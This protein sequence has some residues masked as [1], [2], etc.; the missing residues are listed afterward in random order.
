MYQSL[1]LELAE[2][3]SD[4]FSLTV[5]GTSMR[6]ALRPGDRIVVQKTPV[7]QLQVGD[8][9]VFRRE[10]VVITHRLLRGKDDQLLTK[11]D[12]MRLLDPPVRAEAVLGRADQLLGGRGPLGVAWLSWWEA[13][14]YGWGRLL[15]RYPARGFSLPFTL[16]IRFLLR[17]Y[18][19]V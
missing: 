6:P 17:L 5:N 8:L 14:M 13:K 15:G 10:N 19:T 18:E 4:T 11:G 7:E 1:A 12:N 16:G 2:S 3:G 9:V